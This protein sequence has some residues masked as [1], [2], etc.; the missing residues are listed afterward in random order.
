MTAPAS[1]NTPDRIIRMAMMDAGLLQDGDDPTPEQYANNLNRLNDLVNFWQ[2]D[3]LKLWLQTDLEVELTQGQRLYSL[4]PGGTVDMTKP[5]RVLEGYY[6]YTENAVKRPLIPIAREEYSR[7]PAATQEGTITSYFVDKQATMLNVYLWM[8][9]GLAD[10]SSGTVHLVI[11][12]QVTNV[13]NITEDLE[14]P[15]EW[16]LALRWGLADDICTGQ[17]QAIVQRC[18][19]RAEVF[20]TALENW[21]VEDASTFFAPDT[22]TRGHTGNFR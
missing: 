5:L 22:R 3:G 6:L 13:V 8:A 15:Q 21:D 11:Q 12:R 16:F 19:G 20:K 2:T 14:F 7:L 17:P 1:F 4:G 9:P 18:A 10:A